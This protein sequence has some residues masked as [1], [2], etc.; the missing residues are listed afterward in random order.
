MKTPRQEGES[1][2]GV[3]WN[4]LLVEADAGDV[5]FFDDVW[6]VTLG[7]V[8]GEMLDAVLG[9]EL[10]E[11]VG[12]LSQFGGEP[13]YTVGRSDSAEQQHVVRKMDGSVR[14]CEDY[15]R[16]GKGRVSRG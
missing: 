14:S 5:G 12:E 2:R 3:G 10:H 11:E 9:A 15:E 7:L 6:I 13:F 4:Y 8:D 16:D 1:C